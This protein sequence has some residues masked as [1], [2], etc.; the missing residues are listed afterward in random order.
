M[1]YDIKPPPPGGGLYGLVRVDTDRL[2]DFGISE[3]TA[4]AIWGLGSCE[5]IPERAKAS[6]AT[7]VFRYV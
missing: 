7:D 1:E 4:G 5:E 2:R 3:G 6:R